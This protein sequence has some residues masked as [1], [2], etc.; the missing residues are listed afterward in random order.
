METCTPATGWRSAALSTRPRDVTDNAPP[1]GNSLAVDALLRLAELRHDVDARRRASW[2]LETLAEPIVRY[3]T[4][5]GH[6]LGAA[7]MTGHGAVEVA[8]GTLPT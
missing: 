7:D 2:V 4:A 8:L 6:L 3:P 5:F 1:S